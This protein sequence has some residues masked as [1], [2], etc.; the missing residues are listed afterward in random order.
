MRRF[1]IRYLAL[2][3]H[4]PEDGTGAAAAPAGGD[5]A[6]GASPAAGA[7]AGAAG[8]AAAAAAASPGAAA[9]PAA[10][11]AAAAS[12]YRPEG[13]PDH[14]YGANER[15][16]LDKLF[17]AYS[18]ARETIAKAGDVP[19]AVDGYAFEASE[20]LKPFTEGLDK[21]PFWT[22]VKEVSLKH[23]LPAKSF[24]GLFGDLM[25]KMVDG[26]LVAEPFS[27][28]AERAALVP[29]ITDPK[30]RAA[31]ADRIIR[32]NLAQVKA[33]GEQ[34]LDPASV[35]ALE[36]TMDRAA[37]NK[38]VEW[39]RTSRGEQ[40]PALNGMPAGDITEA[41]LDA[42]IADPRNNFGSPQ[43][44]KAFATETTEMKKKF[45]GK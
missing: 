43:Y 4:A 45:Y 21:D 36:A 9:D 40:P 29:D 16:T 27:P 20:K 37:T 19:K 32:E 41:Q 11:A 3:C 8:A 2:P 23:G 39:I 1:P 5:A 31:T 12:A 42:R 26:G 18:G 34:G 30:A 17:K 14:L 24:Q 15:E 10:A 35:K 28:E 22:T 7:D 38:L 6:A 13:L 33:W 44:D 25:E